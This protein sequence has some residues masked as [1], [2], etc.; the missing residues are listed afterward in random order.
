MSFIF[1]FSLAVSIRSL[2]MISLKRKQY[3]KKKK[4]TQLK[5]KKP[6][7]ALKVCYRVTSST[8]Q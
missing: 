8:I 6:L 3:V 7:P 2:E 4:G 5:R 1:Q